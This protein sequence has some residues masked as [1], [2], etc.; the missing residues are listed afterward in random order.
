MAELHA[1]MTYAG[2]ISLGSQSRCLRFREASRIRWLV[3]GKDERMTLAAMWI[4]SSDGGSRLC[5]ASDSR[6]TPGPIDGVTKVVLFGRSD[7]AGV[8]AGDYRYAALLV[9]HLDAFFTASEAM[10]QR[11]VDLGR[12]LAQAAVSVQRHLRAALG[13]NLPRHDVTPEAQEPG[14][15]TLVVGGY[16]IRLG[17]FVALRIAYRPNPGRW[18]TSTMDVDPARV[19]FLGDGLSLAKRWARLARQHVDPNATIW[20]MEPLLAVDRA[21]AA[22]ALRSVGGMPQLAKAFVQG[23]ALPY[24][25]LNPESGEVWSRS[26]RVSTKGARELAAARRLIDL[27]LWRLHDGRYQGVVS[28][29]YVR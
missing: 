9:S 23:R 21:I 14:E 11:D 26:T 7:V 27:G 20:R 24:G 12:A 1:S 4:D 2:G 3:W 6:T 16:S 13:V 29:P 28:L 25:F 8:W 22:D 19:T 15:T 17:K 5:F 18:S 10:R